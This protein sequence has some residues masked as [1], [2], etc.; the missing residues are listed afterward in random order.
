MPSSI[1]YWWLLSK[2]CRGWI[3]RW[4]MES[5]CQLEQGTIYSWFFVC[6]WSN[7]YRRWSGWIWR[8]SKNQHLLSMINTYFNFSAETEVWE[9][10]NGNNKVINPTLSNNYR[11]GIGIYA[12]DFDYCRKQKDIFCFK[13]NK[14]ESHHKFSLIW[15]RPCG[16]LKYISL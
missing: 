4:Q 5:T 16:E 1:Y 7:N 9:L 12:V 14:L 3:Q 11:Y 6:R 2:D 13:I 8:V 10:A 15:K